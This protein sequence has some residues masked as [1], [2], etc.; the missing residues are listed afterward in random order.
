MG[1]NN[2]DMPA[3]IWRSNLDKGS[4]FA[5][6]GDYMK[7]EAALGF[8]DAMLYESEEYSLYPVVNAQNLSVTG[9][10]DLTVE[11][12]DKMAETYGMTNT[13]FCRDV[14]WPSLVA[15][16]EKG[17]WKITSFLSIKQ[18]NSSGNEPNQSELIDYLKFFNEEGTEAGATLGR[19][20][21]MDVRFSVADERNTLDMWERKYTFAGGYVRKEN[22][23]QITN[24]IDGNGKMEFF[25]DIRTVVGEYEE[26][27]S[28][29][30]WL[31]DQITL[32]NATTSAYR[33]TY[34]DS[35]W[36]KSLET[37]LG[38]SNIQVD[39]YRVLWP[40][41][42]KDE[43]QTVAEKMAANIDTYW[44]PYATFD[45]TTISESDYRV[46]NFLN[47]S[48]ESTRSG[49][50]ISVRT[51]DFVGDHYL[52]FRT[53]GEVLTD[54]TGGDWKEVEEDTYLLHLTGAYASLTVKPAQELYYTE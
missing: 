6:N 10:P 32:Q 43:W 34:K 22:K 15:G 19:I 4:V 8:L 42:K 36:L 47:G 9:F 7:G 14:L 53:H 5:V 2:E 52:M 31:T 54:M 28:V 45:K 17:K 23:E 25:P 21:D 51:K 38:Y 24:L 29:L 26:D 40:E 48:V 18:S 11:N 16:A 37:S 12:E 13:Q 35:L 20:E 33:H 39:M 3:I 30:S 27:T 44:K 1:L 41:S 46:R 49:D 50:Q